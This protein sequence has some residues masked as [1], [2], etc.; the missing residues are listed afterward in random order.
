MVPPIKVDNQQNFLREGDDSTPP[1]IRSKNT[2]FLTGALTHLTALATDATHALLLPLLAHTGWDSQHDL[3]LFI[4]LKAFITH[5]DGSGAAAAQTER[6]RG[7][8]LVILD[9]E[10]QGLHRRGGV[11]LVGLG[12]D[13]HLHD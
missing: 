6:S 4:F 8:K 10:H 12:A 13:N 11:D 3:E 2:Q 7:Q 9:L 1:Q 5:Q